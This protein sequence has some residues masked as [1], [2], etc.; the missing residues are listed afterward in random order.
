MAATM[1]PWER[2][3]APSN[4]GPRVTVASA[5]SPRRCTSM[6]T[7][8]GLARPDTMQSGKCSSRAPSSG[9][10]SKWLEPSRPAWARLRAGSAS[11]SSTNGRTA[12][13]RAS[14]RSSSTW[15]PTR[16]WPSRRSSVAAS[17]RASLTPNSS[18]VSIA[19]E[20]TLPTVGQLDLQRVELGPQAAVGVE[21]GWVDVV[22][23]RAPGFRAVLAIGEPAL[24]RRFRDVGEGPLQALAVGP[25]AEGAQT[26]RVH[27]QPAA[28]QPHQ[29]GGDGG[30]TALLVG[31]HV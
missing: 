17:T 8:I 7:P 12:G 31:S 23:H 19:I 6:A 27:Q 26:R 28:G 9:G 3:G 24:Q 22:A 1:P 29:L 25:Q 2:L 20:P 30:V 21:A 15:W 4:A 13:A 16:A 5:T 14:R 18:T 10:A 11:S